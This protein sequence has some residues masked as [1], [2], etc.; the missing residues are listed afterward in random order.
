MT[1][2]TKNAEDRTYYRLYVA[3]MGR[4]RD[5]ACYEF[6]AEFA[7]ERMAGNYIKYLRGKRRYREKDIILKEVTGA[8]KDP[9]AGKALVAV[10]VM[11]ECLLPDEWD[12]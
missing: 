1:Q 6:V 5:P 4:F 3:D 12:F 11:G 8:D 9:A 10:S 2:Q 7:A